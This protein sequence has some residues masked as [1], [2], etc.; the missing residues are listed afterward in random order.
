LAYR[1]D[2]VAIL[3]GALHDFLLPFP[4]RVTMKGLSPVGVTEVK[5]LESATKAVVSVLTEVRSLHH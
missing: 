4:H 5:R 1:L 3:C 2:L